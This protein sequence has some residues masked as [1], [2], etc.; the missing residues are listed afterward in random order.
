MRESADHL[1]ELRRKIAGIEHQRLAKSPALA[2]LGHT[3]IDSHLGGGLAVG[4][5]HEIFAA[6]QGDVGSATGFAAMVA[7]RMGR[8]DGAIVW[9]RQQDIEVREGQLH[10]PGLIEIGL[11]PSRILLG[12]IPDALGLLRAAAE[13]VR[14]PQVGVAVIEL[15][16]MPRVLDLT[17]SRRLAVACEVSGVTALMLRV[18]AEPAPSAALTRW[19]VG[20]AAS[21]PLEA[22]APGHPVLE[23]SLLRQRGRPA[24]ARWQVEWNRDRLCFREPG[25]PEP[26]LSGLVVP[27]PWRGSAEGQPFR[28]AG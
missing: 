26:A 17:A 24:G 20:S 22:N 28:L 25:F 12:V 9:L 27:L 3:A 2:P 5:L 8:P 10:A 18:E 15:W 14:C 21:A 19:Q 11:N 13:V 1:S 4:R 23:I 7:L 16:R 6:E